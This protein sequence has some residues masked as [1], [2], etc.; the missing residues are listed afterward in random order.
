[1]AL[2]V[3]V[4]ELGQGLERIPA[5]VPTGKK[6]SVPSGDWRLPF[7]HGSLSD[8]GRKFRIY[9]GL[10]IEETASP[11]QVRKIRTYSLSMFPSP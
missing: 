3:L 1:M 8:G 6:F 9:L 11:F 10:L 2:I 4:R 5:R 7:A